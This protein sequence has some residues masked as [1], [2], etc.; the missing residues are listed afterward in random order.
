MG[1]P[2]LRG[3]PIGDT[4]IPTD[5]STFR[6]LVEQSPDG[7]FIL[8]D[9]VFTY[10]NAAALRMFG[11]EDSPPSRL[12]V[13][14]VIHPA[15]H[16]RC[17]R[18]I[19]L[20]QSGALRGA[21]PYRGV[22]RDGD[23]FPIE[24]HT[25]PL[26]SGGGAAL[27]GIVRD[28]SDRQQVEDA[29]L[30]TEH[31]GMLGRLAAGTAHDLN[32]LLT[33]IQA[34]AEVIERSEEDAGAQAALKRILAAV[35]RGEQHV[36]QMHELGIVHA[37]DQQPVP[38]HVNALVEDV[39]NLTRSRWK[40]EAERA[41]VR[42]EI[43]WEPGNAPPVALVPGDLRAAVVAMVFN[44]L[45]AMPSGGRLTLRTGQN[46][47]GQTTISVEDEGAESDDSTLDDLTNLLFTTQ[48]GQKV[49]LGLYLVRRVAEEAGGSLE[50]DSLPGEGSNF[51]LLLPPSKEQP[52]LPERPLSFGG[53]DTRS[54]PTVPDV[55]RPKTVGGRRILIVDDQAD[56]VQVLQTILET[57]GF[58]VDIALRARDGLEHVD[59]VKYSVI[60]TDLGMPDMSGWE[61]AASAR[62]LQPKT[63][64]V[65]MTGW[66]AEIDPSRLERE[67]IHALLPKP[68][69]GQ[70]LLDVIAGALE[71]RRQAAQLEP[72]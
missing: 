42:Y 45:D 29:L 70:E 53:V 41:G 2:E 9:G 49:G 25:A 5:D 13:L 8:V 55:P 63:P 69:R 34:N 52:E 4:V 30:R 39:L 23:T 36:N 24:V 64:L 61:F 67:G 11:W 27:H 12:S 33:V 60:L 26:G 35:R 10:L 56:L 58:E 15:D 48:P 18:N 19:L 43:S 37:P 62:K 54:V 59:A 17:R 40:N 7:H 65:L 72:R 50:L 38:L 47:D 71:S 21:T 66:A 32:N 20:R 1:R 46:E 44:G 31:S 6:L 51:V 57:K 3:L 16:E 22:R 14:D 68:F 28:I